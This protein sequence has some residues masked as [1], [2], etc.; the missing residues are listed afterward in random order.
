M[1]SYENAWPILNSVSGGEFIGDKLDDLTPD[2]KLKAAEIVA[3][4][5]I[6]EELSAIRHHGI[7]QS[8]Q[9]SPD[10]GPGDLHIY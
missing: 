5:A 1:S 10:R 8:G 2:Q 3:L 6:C 4:L 7:A 9:H